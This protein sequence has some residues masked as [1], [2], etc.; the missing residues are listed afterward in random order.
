MKPY[1]W[2]VNP[3]KLQRAITKASPIKD[4]NFIKELYIAMGGLIDKEYLQPEP[5]VEE[6]NQEIHDTTNSE[7]SNPIIAE[8]ESIDGGP[9][10]PRGRPAKSA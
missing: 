2:A 6:S 8:D 7:E 10:R 9:K 3:L 5:V 4:E 1:A